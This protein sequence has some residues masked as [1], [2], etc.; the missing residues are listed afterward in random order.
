MMQA[1]EVNKTSLKT[2]T[3]Q[4]GDTKPSVEEDIDLIDL[5]NETIE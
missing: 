2:I 5:S 4:V 3:N 1:R